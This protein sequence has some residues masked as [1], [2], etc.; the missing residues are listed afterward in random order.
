MREM[1]RDRLSRFELARQAHRS[2][3]G[4][5]G[6]A[7]ARAIT[8]FEDFYGRLS[9]PERKE[10]WNT[11]YRMVEH[12]EPN[13][14]KTP[15]QQKLQR[16]WGTLSEDDRRVVWNY[17]YKRAK[18]GETS[19]TTNPATP[20]IAKNPA[21]VPRWRPPPSKFKLNDIVMFNGV[22][23]EV[24]SMEWDMEEGHWSYWL[25]DVATKEWPSPKFRVHE[26]KL[27]PETSGV[28]KRGNDYWKTF[29][30]VMKHPRTE[31]LLKEQAPRHPQSSTKIQTAI[32][33]MYD[34]GKAQSVTGLQGGIPIQSRPR[35]V[36][37]IIDRIRR[38]YSQ[39]EKEFYA[40]EYEKASETLDNARILWHESLTKEEAEKYLALGDMLDKLYIR[41]QM[42][43]REK[44]QPS[45]K[46]SSG[47]SI[48]TDPSTAWQ[49]TPENERKIMLRF[50]G[51]TEREVNVF[52]RVEWNRLPQNIIDKLTERYRSPLKQKGILLSSVRPTCEAPPHEGWV[53]E[54]QRD[55]RGRIVTKTVQF[56]AKELADA[57]DYLRRMYQGWLVAKLEREKHGGNR[58]VLK[59]S[60]ITYPTNA[61]EPMVIRQKEYV[62]VPDHI[63]EKLKA[64]E[65]TVRVQ[66]IKERPI[67]KP[68]ITISN[69]KEAADL[70][71]YMQ[72]YDREFVKAL[73]MDSK[74]QLVALETISIGGINYT[75]SEP[76]QI[77]KTAALSNSDRVI[78]VHN[79][80][81]GIAEPSYTDV[82][83]CRKLHSGLKLV[84]IAMLDF[85]IIGKDQYVSIAD[86]NPEIW[87]GY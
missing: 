44:A 42:E 83:S 10:V 86:R 28:S 70:V 45:V 34:V 30:Q 16:L 15:A 36:R 64:L 43:S 71:R 31:Q 2:G 18:G 37:S 38:L 68:K 47:V 58:A 24:R 9:N 13:P 19:H 14:V 5:P 81:S 69:S 59:D 50:I 27:S 32:T 20:P 76:M 21:G 11:L 78:I 35:S 26:N 52:A 87:R 3:P 23:K 55:I 74:N 66:L 60:P 6:P 51:L 8:L 80:P 57:Q 12:N 22:R 84:N 75:I 61:A 79:H 77:I 54:L 25:R 62:A 40:K 4:S 73:Y 33:R 82:E 67:P 1:Y 39:A 48:G 65:D 53:A 17:V 46:S 41:L 85:I 72:D 7:R 29:T 49:K 56:D 63:P